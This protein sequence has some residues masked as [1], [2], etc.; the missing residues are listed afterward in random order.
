MRKLKIGLTKTFKQ[1]ALTLK[2]FG[3]Y[4]VLV[5]KKAKGTLHD[6]QTYQVGIYQG[7]R[8]VIAKQ[9]V[10]DKQIYL[11]GQTGGEILEINGVKY[12]GNFYIEVLKNRFKVINHLELED[13]LYGVVGKEIIH[14]WPFET[15]RAQAVIA[16]TYTLHNLNKHK[17]D[18]YDLTDNS[19]SQVY[20][21]LN[22]ESDKIRKAVDKTVGEVI[23]YHK[24]LANVYYYSSCGG[25]TENI[26]NVWYIKKSFAYLRGKRCAYCRT[27]PVFK[28]EAKLK[29]SEIKTVLE[30]KGYKMGEI[31]KIKVR[32]YFK[33]GRV[34]DISIHWRG[35][36]FSMKATDFRAF[37]YK[38]LKSTMFKLNNKRDSVY[39]KGKGFG[40]GVGLCQYGAKG[41]SDKEYSYKTI[42]KN[43]FPKTEF[44]QWTK[45]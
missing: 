42:I 23:A 17:E 36:A 45:L 22:A 27:A 39:F 29:F 43:Y 4:N 14:S 2:A 10:Y 3:S 30:K 33:S 41:M 13:Y 6:G 12:R 37:F 40:H 9:K 15:I 11:Q 21:G 1:N 7:K 18:G 8:V 31:N 28:W 32:R 34:R 24:K 25:H 35:G 26:Q 16:R 20:G 44:K 19:S 5:N 38:H